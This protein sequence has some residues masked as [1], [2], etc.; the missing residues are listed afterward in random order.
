VLGWNAQYGAIPECVFISFPSLDTLFSTNEDL[1]AEE[2]HSVL[3]VYKYNPTTGVTGPITMITKDFKYSSEIT[4][5]YGAL[6]TN[7]G[8]A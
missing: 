7:V 1:I 2:L 8:S 6:A 5:Y 4:N 3:E